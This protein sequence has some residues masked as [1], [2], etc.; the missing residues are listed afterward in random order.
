M[1]FYLRN[2]MILALAACILWLL[3]KRWDRRRKQKLRYEEALAI[4]PLAEELYGR[5]A[6]FQK[7]DEGAR[8]IASVPEREL[9]ETVGMVLRGLG[10]EELPVYLFD[11]E[12]DRDDCL[13]F[14]QA[15]Q[16]RALELYLPRLLNAI[17][18]NTW[19]L[20]EQDW[21]PADAREAEFE[22]APVTPANAKKKR[23]RKITPSRIQS[24]ILNAASSFGLTLTPD[25]TPE[26]GP[27]V[28]RYFFRLPQG[29]KLSKVTNLA[30][31]FALAIGVSGVRIAPV[32]GRQGVI[33]MEIPNRKPARVSFREMVE[34]DAFKLSKSPLTFALGRDIGGRPVV[35]DLSAMPHILIAGTTGSGKSVCLNTLICAILTKSAP[36]QVRFILI[37]P[38]RVELSG[39]SEIPHLLKPV[40]TD[41]REAADALQWAVN[42]M[43][44]R[45]TK[46]KESKVRS[47]SDYKGTL[48]YIVIVIDEMADLMTASGKA[49]EESIVRIAQMGRAAGIHL[50]LATQRPTADVVTGLIKSNI[51]A[52]IA[53][54]VSSS[55]ESRI[56]LDDTGAEKLLGRG[57]MLYAPPGSEKIR[58]QGCMITE[59]EIR[60][61]VKQWKA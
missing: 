11:G 48:P 44:Q 25:G 3:W 26:I 30:D 19:I 7:L 33:G 38:K 40:V 56:I 46:F 1:A 58:V 32:A 15:K 34:S 17:F 55:L 21:V 36:E 43:T 49:V 2:L 6:Q 4:V 57:D 42:E 39:Y 24:D 27:S 9:S 45:Y 12:H 59:K 35:G 18:E 31:D 51:P 22:A 50:I 52:R 29:I 37:D 53:F 10:G 20:R 47:I 28:T 5:L 16:R 41:P 23:T 13:A 8:Q 14:I 54:A 61:A 60:K